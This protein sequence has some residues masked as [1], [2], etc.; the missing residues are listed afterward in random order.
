MP[1]PCPEGSTGGWQEMRMGAWV[2]QVSQEFLDPRLLCRLE[3]PAQLLRP[4]A[5]VIERIPPRKFSE[6]AR[7][8]LPEWPDVPLFVKHLG[9]I[10]FK[11]ALKS[12]LRPTRARRA[13]E[14]ALLLSRLK[15]RTAI[16]VATGERRQWLWLREAFLIFAEVPE[17]TTLYHFYVNASDSGPR[18]LAVRSLAR[19]MARLHDAGLSHSDAHPLNFLI[20]H[21]DCRKLVMIDLEAVRRVPAFRFRT[22]VKDLRKLLRRSPV[23]VREKIWF[24]TEYCR[25]RTPP[26]SA[27]ELARRLNPASRAQRR[28]SGED[29]DQTTVVRGGLVWRIRPS[30]V[31]SRVETILDSPDE[32]LERARVLKPDRSS[33]VGADEGVVVKR[34]NYRK[35]MSRLKDAFRQSRGPRCFRKARL[36]EAVGVPVARAVAA[37]ERRRWGLVVRSYFV[38]EE[39]L[40]AIHWRDW[41]GHKGPVIHATARVIAR[42]HAAGFVHRDLKEANILL[43]K[44]GEPFL[45]DLDGVH[46]VGR[47]TERQAVADLVRLARGLVAA[48]QATRADCAR[49]LKAYCRFRHAGDWRSWWRLM[50]VEWPQR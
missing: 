36:L 23:S 34:Y 19:L 30:M 16:P 17:S 8:V 11:E 28:I 45:V 24:C 43:D 1:N 40:G 31:D 2:W 20:A 10:S 29:V 14:N 7:L 37:S 49:F 12:V 9:P 41:T 13:F 42:L 27:R 4:P 22:A 44:R 38:M 32:F 35:W 39:I 50:A 48:T 18:M 5:R 33:A 46:H 26:L 3:S 15:I 6:L 47:V 21:S 25:S